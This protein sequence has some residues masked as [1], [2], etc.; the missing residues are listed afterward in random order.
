[1]VV[2][3]GADT[4][5][6]NIDSA[7]TQTQWESLIEQAIDKINGYGAKYGVELP[8][9][10][11]DAGSKSVNVTSAEA[12]FIRDLAVAIYQ[13]DAK[14]GG[15]QSTSYGLGALSH[16][17]SASSG[18]SLEELAKEAASQLKEVDVSYG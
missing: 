1:M 9:M 16:S 3:T 4:F 10:A 8:N 14:S 6:T 7:L 17:Q 11:G 12:G 2:L 15:A 18:N 5:F 13:K